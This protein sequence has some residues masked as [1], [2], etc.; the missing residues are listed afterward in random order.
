MVDNLAGSSTNTP[1]AFVRCLQRHRFQ[2]QTGRNKMTK[3]KRLLGAAVL[4][5]TFGMPALAEEL[6]L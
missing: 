5:T 4:A 3:T 6:N 2:S 1:D